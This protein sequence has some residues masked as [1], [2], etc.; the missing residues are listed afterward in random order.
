[1]S[2]DIQRSGKYQLFETT[3]RFRMINLDDRDFFIWRGPERLELSD[4]GHEASEIIHQGDYA[5]FTS[6]TETD[7]DEE[8]TYLA[9]QEGNR[10]RVYALPQGLPSHQNRLVDILEMSE[11]P[12]KY[13]LGGLGV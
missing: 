6:Q 5:L 12:T 11:M 4:M 13:G 2:R 1:M 10:Y 3:Q 8:S 7:F 9:C